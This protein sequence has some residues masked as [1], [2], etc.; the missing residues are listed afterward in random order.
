MKCRKEIRRWQ[1]RGVT[2]VWGLFCQGV[3]GGWRIFF[4]S[5]VSLFDREARFFVPTRASLTLARAGAV[6]VGRRTNLAACS[7]LARPYLDGFEHDGT[8]GVV[9]MTIREEPA[10]G[11]GSIAPQPC[12]RLGPRTPNHDAAMRI[13]SEAPKRRTHSSSRHDS[14]ESPRDPATSNHHRRPVKWT[15]GAETIRCV[16]RSPVIMPVAERRPLE[17]H[18]PARAARER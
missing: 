18:P 6:K 14:H 9:G 15:D 4:A 1:N 12:I 11:R 5:S 3:S 10:F 13:G 2:L 16:Q 17:P 8:L 7:A